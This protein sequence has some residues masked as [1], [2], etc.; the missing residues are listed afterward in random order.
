MVSDLP[1]AVVGDIDHTYPPRRR[2]GAVHCVQAHAVPPDHSEARRRLHHR[3][4]DG[5]VLRE[6]AVGP[7]YGRDGLLLRPAPFD[8]HLVTSVLEYGELGLDGAMVT[9]G[10][11]NPAH[12]LPP[13]VADK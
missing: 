13:S 7:G 6:Q 4:G 11:D 2:R 3:A 12:V 10:D 5:R 9:I 8:Y 1:D